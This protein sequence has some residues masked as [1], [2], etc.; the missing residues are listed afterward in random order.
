MAANSDAARTRGW[1]LWDYDRAEVVRGPYT[2]GE[3]AGAVRREIEGDR[4]LW[5]VNEEQIVQWEAEL[6][7]PRKN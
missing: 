3:T 6:R 7:L 4:N 2:T 5:I 1:Y